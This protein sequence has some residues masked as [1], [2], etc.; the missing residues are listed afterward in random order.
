MKSVVGRGAVSS[1]LAAGI[2]CLTAASASVLEGASPP[3]AALAEVLDSLRADCALLDG[4]ALSV[5]WGALSRPD[6]DGDLEPDWVLDGRFLSCSTSASLFCG[7]T[8]GCWTY[9]LVGESAAAEF[10]NQGWMLTDFGGLRILLLRAHGSECGGN[11]LSPCVRALTW[12]A[13]AAQWR[14]VGGDGR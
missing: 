11:N 4:G 1:A 3:P 5:E 10:L 13:R 6:L 7:G 14:A 8:G 2:F 12:D 9:F